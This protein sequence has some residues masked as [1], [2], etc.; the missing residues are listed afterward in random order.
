MVREVLLLAQITYTGG[1]SSVALGQGASTGW[2][3]E[4]HNVRDVPRGG[5]RAIAI[6]GKCTWCHNRFICV[7][8]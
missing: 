6:G 4:W 8:C 7:W 2:T 1:Q 3:G 5:E